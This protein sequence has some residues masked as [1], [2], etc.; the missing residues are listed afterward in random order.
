MAAASR[1][2]RVGLS[3]MSVSP[4]A[5]PSAIPARASR[6]TRGLVA[7]VVVAWAVALVAPPVA[8]VR[9]RDQRLAELADPAAQA[10]WD[11]F[12]EAMQRESGRD[13]PVQRKVPKSAEPP[14]RVWLRDHLG[15]AVGAW[16]L[17]V[18][19]LGGFLC[20]L[21]VGVVTGRGSAAPT[22]PPP[23]KE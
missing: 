5:E 10:G 13:G 14:E 21:F 17:F 4:P 8:L 15:L 3:R 22:A 2:F 12:R 1:R 23:G 19:V 7:G 6:L 20:L 11:A 16:L 9:W 18:G